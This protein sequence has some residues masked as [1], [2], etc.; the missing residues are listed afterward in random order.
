[1]SQNSALDT[2]E[3]INKLIPKLQRK[4]A[5]PNLNQIIFNKTIDTKSKQLINKIN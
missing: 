2:L 1:M 5:D 4:N 3:W